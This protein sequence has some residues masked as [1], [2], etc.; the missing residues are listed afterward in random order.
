[1]FLTLLIGA[2]AAA[3]AADVWVESSLAQVYP[4]SAPG[5]N[6]ANEIRIYAAQGERESVQLCVRIGADQPI[7]AALDP[8]T[9]GDIIPPAS[10]RIVGYGALD[11]PSPRAASTELLLP[12]PLLPASDP[13][14]ALSPGRTTV[15]WLT[16]DI[17][18]DTPP[19]VYTGR[20]LLR[21]DG[22]PNVRIPV[23]VEV[24]DFEMPATPALPLLARI[25]RAAAAEALGIDGSD[26][27]SW[28][29]F[30][31]KL[32]DYGIAAPLWGDDLVRP[33]GLSEVDAEAFK[34]HL[35]WAAARGMSVLEV[36]DPH[37]GV[38]RF[39]EPVGD[40]EPD[41][42]QPYL[43]DIGR[44]LDARGWLDKAV[45]RV[46]A[47][48]RRDQ[49]ETTQRAA[50]RLRLADQRVRRL[51]AGEPHPSFERFAEVWAMPLHAW[52][53]SI[54]DR[55]RRGYSLQ[56]PPRPG[57]DRVTG[58]ES[59]S[60]PGWSYVSRPED[61]Y[62]GSLFSAWAPKM[63]A[64][65]GEPVWA[66]ID[67]SEIADA[68]EITVGF[69]PGMEGGEVSVQTSFS[70]VL[71]SRPKMTWERYDDIHPMGQSWA[72][73]QFSMTKRVASL[74]VVVAPRPDG[75]PIAI[76]EIQFGIPPE[77]AAVEPMA[78][79]APWL[80]LLPG[81]FP[82]H[83][84]DAHPAEARL[85][86]W[87]CW[88]HEFAGVLMGGV[89]AW[90]ASWR[91]L[92]EAMPATWTGLPSAQE[93]LFYPGRGMTLASVQAER[94]RDG[95]EDYVYLQMEAALRTPEGE[96]RQ[97]LLDVSPVFLESPG[98]TT[99]DAWAERIER[100]RILIGRRLTQPDVP[101]ALG[102]EGVFT[103]GSMSQD[104]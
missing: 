56:A 10:I 97:S 61:A 11:R 30:Y 8:E 86:P 62:D 98:P 54:V 29:P 78:P 57:A 101:P 38:A 20:Y 90:P 46:G 17:P 15:Y 89:A 103:G 45:F 1:M 31:G 87:V 104:P 6:P 35:S 92:A 68:D 93:V 23:R 99:L 12:G 69:L 47:L 91:G 66:Q 58:T 53:P 88:G 9:I 77:D 79:I 100:T 3:G 102:N 48:P 44:W 67:F 22:V 16:F 40:A 85:I 32:I 82:A 14:P 36:G 34:D 21:L 39:R 71:F 18:R 81:R 25:D 28:R 24:F 63:T 41:P 74:Q 13:L 64:I 84:L 94:L 70:G 96:T 55:F 42:L 73:G 2:F 51:L 49:W 52:H 95:L 33:R 72:R 59:G 37:A 4:T 76:N 80:Q 27:A 65:G 60:L 43:Q 75:R 19:G 7:G 50:L 83:T 5:P 26:L